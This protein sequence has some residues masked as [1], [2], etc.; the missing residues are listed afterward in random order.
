M[1]RMMV[2][3]IMLV[4]CFLVACDDGVTG[5]REEV[6]TGWGKR[7]LQEV[8]GRDLE[9][10]NS[11]KAQ[12]DAWDKYD[13]V[14]FRQ[15]RLLLPD[16]KAFAEWSTR[17]MGVEELARE[18]MDIMLFEGWRDG[19]LM[20]LVGVEWDGEMWQKTGWS[21]ELEG[22]VRWVENVSKAVEN[23]ADGGRFCYLLW[24]E[25]LWWMYEVGGEPR[26]RGP[27]D[28]GEMTVEE[29]AEVAFGDDGAA[30]RERELEVG[31]IHR[32]RLQTRE[33]RNPPTGRR[34]EL[35]RESRDIFLHGRGDTVYL[36][37]EAGDVLQSLYP[38]REGV[39]WQTRRKTR[40]EM[41]MERERELFREMS[42][43]PSMMMGGNG[44]TWYWVFQER[45][46]DALVVDSAFVVGVRPVTREEFAAFYYRE[47]RRR[48]MELARTGDFRWWIVLDCF[49]SDYFRQG[50]LL[51][52]TGDGRFS[53]HGLW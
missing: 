51:V 34:R 25:R 6:V 17:E 16:E 30:D 33:W 46:E 7:V 3:V 13:G 15:V 38:G 20:T 49:L 9:D 22:D 41:R 2:S 28:D 47:R 36:L 4:G 18:R 45:W 53:L 21:V 40:E 26:F 1:K 5:L 35:F 12:I 39:C 37:Y 32:R 27:G 29:F 48:D 50:Y 8:L 10:V 23:Q 19:R 43:I 44:I 31:S 24:A 52:P 11:S 14:E 42:G